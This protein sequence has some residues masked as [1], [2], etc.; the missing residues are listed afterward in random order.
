MSQWLIYHISRP[1]SGIIDTSI[2]KPDGQRSDESS[3]SAQDGSPSVPVPK[4]KDITS[5]G[6]LLNNFP[7]IARQMQPGLDRSFR[8]FTATVERS[9][10]DET[11]S[12][13]ATTLNENSPADYITG[14]GSLAKTTN[15]LTRIPSTASAA[16]SA[17][18]NFL[19][20]A[21]ETLVL[22]A[23]DTFQAVD[24]QQLSH[25]GEI[26]DLSGSAIEKMIEKYVSE[27]VH[28]SSLFPRVLASMD[29]E[30]LELDGYLKRMSDV[31]IAQIGI[32]DYGGH[33]GKRDLSRRIVSGVAV[34]KK[35]GTASS[36]QEMLDILME[37]Q[38]S[39]TA[40]SGSST[41][42]STGT[43]S[44]KSAQ[45]GAVS[46]DTLVSLLLMVV[47]RSPV[48]N[49]HARLTYVRDFNLFTDV[50]NGQIGYALSTFEGV[51]T[52]LSGN[53]RG[54]RRISQ[55]NK[56][57]WHSVRTGDIATVKSLLDPDN[58]DDEP[59]EPGLSTEDGSDVEDDREYKLR[60]NGI[61]PSQ[62]S[63]QPQR[64]TASN[65]AHIFPFR[66]NGTE[67]IDGSPPKLKKRVSMDT[68]SLS[69]SSAHSNISGA[70]TGE[71]IRS[72]ISGETSAEQLVQT[73]DSLGNSV[74]FMAV[75][76]S[77]AKVLAYLLQLESLVTPDLVLR[78]QTNDGTSLLSAAVQHSTTKIVDIVLDYVLR[79]TESD[80]ALMI[81]LAYQDNNGRSV[82]HYCFSAPYLIASIGHLLPWQQKDKNG[83]TPLFAMC[84]SYDH[85]N[86][87]ALAASAITA[88]TMYQRDGLPL[89]L[90]DHVD[91]KGNTLLH[92]V[93]DTVLVKQLLI[94]CNSDPNAQNL[95][96]FTPLMVAS[97]FARMDL[98]RVFFADYR[99]DLQARDFRGFTAVEVAKDDDVRNQI[100]DMV[101][102]LVASDPGE[103]KTT[104]VRALLVDDGSIRLVIKSGAP[105]DRATITVTTCRRS[106]S[107]FENL[108]H[109]LSLEHPASWIPAISNLRSPFQIIPRPSKQILRD[110]QLRLNGF[111]QTM[112]AHPTFSTHEMLWEFFL[113]PDIDQRM[114]AERARRK[115]EIRVENLALDY[116]PLTS[117]A[118]IAELEVFIGH[119]IDQLRHT[120][121]AL[122]WTTRKVAAIRNSAAGIAEA[123]RFAAK[124]FVDAVPFLPSTHHAAL[125]DYAATL[126]QT[127]YSPITRLLYSMYTATGSSAALLKALS[128]P[129]LLIGS[130]AAQRATIAKHA[131]SLRRAQAWPSAIA[132]LGL[133]DAQ[134]K[135]AEAKVDKARREMDMLGRELRYTQTTVASEFAGW[136]DGHAK[137]VRAAL[138]EWVKTMRDS[139]RA[140]LVAMER[141]RR[142]ILKAKAAP[143][144]S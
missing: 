56:S 112:L 109:W 52:Y 42:E 81:Y 62:N 74:L 14:T 139:E 117:P 114:L 118:E 140:R 110:I 5:F 9:S 23:I 82:A 83:Q 122:K 63:D 129:S 128:R 125:A 121:A 119:A 96:R 130:L 48:R 127:E 142:G 43:S 90:A 41:F 40:S 45:G 144:T 143:V 108:V 141:A 3:S 29:L 30:D 47:I 10:A 34:F 60:S 111:L 124:R 70:S 134:Q 69:S 136:Q 21:L 8:Q 77:Q 58:Q 61:D 93:N 87:H 31:D 99:V 102:L 26:T 55:M 53:S 94:R 67:G 39:L 19:R 64:L 51:L 4:K 18:G 49:L 92:I 103:R 137:S 46:A 105:S 57:L 115:A 126:S 95:K 1:L 76:S 79:H 50:E 66:T 138:K 84:R 72:M 100:D 25:L 97:K 101:L 120:H 20:E 98:V 36:P 85:D 80:H 133:L 13:S 12:S 113:V 71:S 16:L 28:E 135:D 123:H 106:L 75:E 68:R 104:I 11:L 15:E 17:Y 116:S 6:D 2:K 27:H 7:M 24:K 86:Y 38:Q 59:D 78:Y 37:T 131:A 88:A 132:G 44:E 73:Q 89:Q 22:S 65:L 35:L 91:A 107:D 33:N 32:E 54:L